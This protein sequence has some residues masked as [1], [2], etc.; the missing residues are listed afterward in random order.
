MDAYDANALL[1]LGRQRFRNFAE[2]T[3]LILGSLEEVL[4]GTVALARLERDEYVYRVVDARGEGIDGLGPGTVLRLAGEGIDPNALSELGALDWISSPL[5]MSNGQI[6]GV[7]CAAD[8]GEG[9]YRPGHEAL[10]TIAARLL[11]YE[12]ETVELRSELRRL[13]IRVN[14]GPGFDADT[15]LPDRESFLH[16]A[17]HEWRL[18]QRGTV[19]S[20]LIACRVHGSGQNGDAASDAKQTLALKVAAEV[21]EGSTRETDRVGRVGAGTIGVVLVGCRPQDTPSFIA[22]FLSALE[23]VSGDDGADV[24]VSC[25]VQ[26]LNEASSPEE[27]LGLAEAAATAEVERGQPSAQG[28]GIE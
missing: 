12:W 8:S 2:A 17:G 16:L 7:L 13:R 27:A 19:Q 24:K 18:A 3:D 21:L 10:L 14:A 20:V 28:A 1:R 11:G 23:R 25:G 6:A 4:P 9:V 26:P 5:E 22:R 15:G